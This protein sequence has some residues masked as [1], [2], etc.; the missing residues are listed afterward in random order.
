[1]VSDIRDE[2][3]LRVSQNRVLRGIFIPKWDEMKGSWRELHNEELCEFYSSPGVIRIIR[4]RRVRLGGN[5]EQMHMKRNAYRALVGK[6]E[7]KRPL[8]RPRC[9]WVDILR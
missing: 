6:Q 1:L 2:H 9:G 5:I 3:R 4:L 7:G 8:G